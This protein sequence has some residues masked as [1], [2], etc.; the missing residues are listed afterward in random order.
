MSESKRVADQIAEMQRVV[1]EVADQSVYVYLHGKEIAK[2]SPA[3]MWHT[4]PMKEGMGCEV[5]DWSP[6]ANRL[7]LAKSYGP[8]EW[9]TCGRV[10]TG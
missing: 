3:A 4:V 5:W 7:I 2:Y 8:G 10:A 1:R 6:I 9:T